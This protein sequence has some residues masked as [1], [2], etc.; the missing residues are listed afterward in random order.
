MSKD[1][2]SPP[3][4]H[5]P[6]RPSHSL[7]GRVAIVTGAGSQS[8][9]IGNGRAAAI[10]LAEAGARVVCADI[11]A[12]WAAHT[13]SMIASESGDDAAV[14]VQADVAKSGDCERTVNVALSRFGR[15]DILINNVGVGGPQGTAVDVNLGEWARGL[16]INVTSMMLMAKYAVP[17]MERNERREVSGRGA[18]VNIASVAGLIGGTPMLLYPT[19]KGAIVNMTRAMAAHHAPAGIRVNWMLYTP[20]LYSRGMSTEVREARRE[21]SL[22]KTEGN[23]WDTGAAVRFLASDEARWITGVI[24]PVDAG[25]TAAIPQGGALGKANIF[26]TLDVRS[27]L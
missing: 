27:K 2:P 1:E 7:A 3:T 5:S 18:I 25:T 20:M 26:S 6:P 9:G 17:A 10:L 14:A 16:E 12:A 4:D 11:N 22:L 19:T 8:S 23:G 13:V 21:R 24:L 15:L